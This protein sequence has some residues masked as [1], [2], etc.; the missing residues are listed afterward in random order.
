MS[1]KIEDNSLQ[2]SLD[3]GR[4]TNL[5]LRFLLDDVERNSDPITPKKEGELRR[6]VLKS[7]VGMKASIKWVK[8]YAA[9]QEAGE[10]K[11][12]VFRKYTTPGTGRSFAYKG[13]NAAVVN[14]KSTMQKA[15][16]I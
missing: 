15:K 3:M 13:V 1:V 8:E 10:A 5:F 7:V 6:G 11:G 9:P 12:H 4:N 14:A 2:V 16:L